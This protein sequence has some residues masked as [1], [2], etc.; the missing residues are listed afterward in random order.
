MYKFQGKFLKTQYFHDKNLYLFKVQNLDNGRVYKFAYNAID[1]LQKLINNPNF[2][3]SEENL[4]Y[5]SSGLIG[6]TKFF[7]VEK[8]ESPIGKTDWNMIHKDP[9]KASLSMND[10]EIEEIGVN[11]SQYPDDEALEELKDVDF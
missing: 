7:E 5:I 6:K 3:P 1:F 10:D 9:H 4:E 2:S 8:D 11:L